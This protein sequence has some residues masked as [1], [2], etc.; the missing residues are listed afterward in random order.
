MLQTMYLQKK[1]TYKSFTI[2]RE[3]YNYPIY[4]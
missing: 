1:I 3:E 2:P 4:F